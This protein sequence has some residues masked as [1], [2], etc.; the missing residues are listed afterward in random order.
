MR[1]RVAVLLA[2]VV[3]VGGCGL[4]HVELTAQ[5]IGKDAVTAYTG[6]EKLKVAR[7]RALEYK[8][9]VQNK[10]D[11]NRGVSLALDVVT[12]GLAVGGG[13]AAL[14]DAHNDVTLGLGLGAVGTNTINALYFSTDRTAVFLSAAD[15]L[16]CTVDAAD[17]TAGARDQ[18][19][20]LTAGQAE[21]GE[22]DAG[23]GSYERKLLV[24]LNLLSQ[25]NWGANDAD[26]ARYLAAGV[27]AGRYRA[28]KGNIA[29]FA[30]QDV[31][32]AT[33]VNETVNLV[34]SDTNKKL[35]KL[36]PSPQEVLKA[37][38]A[39]SVGAVAFAKQVTPAADGAGKVQNFGAD[40]H[41][42][43]FDPAGPAVPTVP[44]DLERGLLEAATTD[45]ANAAT[46]LQGQLDA[47][48]NRMADIA[49]F[50]VAKVSP[51]EPLELISSKAITVE[52][53]K[54]T[55]VAKFK[56]GKGLL[57]AE[58]KDPKPD[59]KIEILASQENPAVRMVYV[60]VAAK[61]DKPLTLVVKDEKVVPAEFE[62]T[63]TVK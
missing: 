27:A 3:A 55:E 16:Q 30:G 58:F 43:G 60:T 4:S 20:A 5:P 28:A 31:G 32:F 56:G 10:Q 38:T 51:P 46:D 47:A 6:F 9:S 26:K 1:V 36:Q 59:A 37:A 40:F 12:I 39:I 22:S 8:K 49:T 53:G 63:V 18:V 44:S 54:R 2:A 17:A 14:Y 7:E 23:L 52:A 62:I 35:D 29:T 33:A 24:V 34:I 19:A 42:E 57:V 48:T 25:H 15:A 45:L 50:C 61:S 21:P 41:L 13:V 11:W